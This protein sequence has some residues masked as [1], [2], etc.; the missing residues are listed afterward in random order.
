MK[1]YTHAWLAFMAIKRLEDVEF[2]GNNGIY[3]SDLIRWFKNHKDGVI[4]G[5]WYPDSVT[6]RH[7]QKPC[8]QVYT[9]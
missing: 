9:L 4:R 8:A 1:Q 6:K 5:A 2:T 7:G 3:A